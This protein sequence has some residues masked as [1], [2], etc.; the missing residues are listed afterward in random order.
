[1]P[2]CRSLGKGL[3][4]IRSS[5][6]DNLEARLL[7][8]LK[9]DCIRVVN[10]FLKKMRKTS[11]EEIELALKRMKEWNHGDEFK[12]KSARRLDS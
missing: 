8:Y 1:M 7:F 10:G 9:D 12:R 2:L 4:E 11:R 3:W 5:L 6:A